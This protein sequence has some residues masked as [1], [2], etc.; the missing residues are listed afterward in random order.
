MATRSMTRGGASEKPGGA[1]PT[2][3]VPP[4]A[5]MQ[6]LADRHGMTVQALTV[7]LK[8]TC[9]PE[10][11]DPRTREK[12]DPTYGE[13]LA[14]CITAVKYGLD[15]FTKEIFAFPGKGGGMV[16]VVSVDGRLRKINE[17]PAHDGM[18]VRIDEWEKRGQKVIPVS[19]TCTIWRKDRSKPIVITEYYDECYRNTEPWNGMPARQLRHKAI[20]ECSRVAYGL[21]L[22]D[23]DEARDIVARETDYEVVEPSTPRRAPESLDDMAAAFEGRREKREP[24]PEPAPA[25][26]PG[27]DDDAGEPAEGESPV[28]GF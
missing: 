11:G 19:A 13:V 26:E 1:E 14:F 7:A 28:S 24:Q 22:P 27:S 18:E 6:V 21:A 25:R 9:F 16:P 20:K 2:A 3:P 5:A 4:V 23:E 17:H 8:A 12:R 10:V 15:P